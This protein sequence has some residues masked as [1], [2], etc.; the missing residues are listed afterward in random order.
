MRVKKSLWSFVSPLAAAAMLVSACTGA[1]S[2]PVATQAPANTQAP[3]D[4]Q[5]VSPTEVPATLAP[6][7]TEAA[8]NFSGTATITF[9]QEPDNLNPLYTSMWFSGITTQFWLKGV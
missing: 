2:T 5:A 6:E 9:V 8:E 7:P 3:A 4:T 1:P